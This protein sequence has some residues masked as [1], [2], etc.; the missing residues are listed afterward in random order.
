MYKTKKGKKG[1]SPK[2]IKKKWKHETQ[3]KTRINLAILGKTINQVR[4][5][6]RSQSRGASLRG[7]NAKSPTQPRGKNQLHPNMKQI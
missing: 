2:E 6:V 5:L 3:K 1:K 7:H 4:Y